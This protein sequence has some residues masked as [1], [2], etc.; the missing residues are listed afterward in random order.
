MTADR[1]ISKQIA[2]N[3][4]LDLKDSSKRL[5]ADAGAIDVPTLVLGAGS[6]WVVK[7]STTRTFFDGLSSVRKEM[8]IFA[9]MGHSIFH[10]VGRR[11][12]A[13]RISKFIRAEFEHAAP[14]T[15]DGVQ[16]YT[17]REFEILSAPLPFYS[18]KNMSF[19]SQRLSLATVLR[20]SEGVRMGHETGFDSGESLDYVYRNQARGITPLGRVMD[21]FYLN[22]IG[23][24]GIRIRRQNIDTLLRDAI[25]QI[26]ES[27][28]AVRLLDIAAG[29]GRYVIELL[30]SLGDV[31]IAATLRDRSVT[32]LEEGRAIGGAGGREAC[33]LRNR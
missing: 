21:Y 7:N 28:A 25:A 11:D 9:G 5:V 20:L 27:G 31:D 3:V 2:T 19:K 32:A 8:H 1:L 13:D 16:S 6:D 10:E 33:H 26:Q 24:R 30:K 17:R 29:A 23:W 14:A 15:I 12:V 22:A 4:L 18:P